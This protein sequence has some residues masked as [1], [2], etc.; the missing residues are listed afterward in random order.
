MAYIR[1]FMVYTCVYIESEIAISLIGHVPGRMNDET[2][3]KMQACVAYY[4]HFIPIH[5][6]TKEQDNKKN[7]HI[8][9]HSIQTCLRLIT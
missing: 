5:D 3:E 7:C 2:R 8:L 6:M 9:L 4:K 1:D